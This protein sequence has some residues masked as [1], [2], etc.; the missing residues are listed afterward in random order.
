MQW[1]TS[2]SRGRHEPQDSTHALCRRA[3]LRRGPPDV[4][5]VRGCQVE[6]QFSPRWRLCADGAYYQQCQNG[7]GDR[8]DMGFV[9]C[10][11]PSQ[12]RICALL[13]PPS[14][15]DGWWAGHGRVCMAPW[16]G[17]CC[18]TARG[19]R[20]RRARGILSWSGG[21]HRV[22]S[23]AS[24]GLP[25]AAACLAAGCR[26]SRRHSFRGCVGGQQQGGRAPQRL[27]A[28]PL[29]ITDCCLRA[30]N[31][32]SRA[33]SMRVEGLLQTCGC[34]APTFHLTHE[35]LWIA[36]PHAL[37]AAAAAPWPAL[38]C[39]PMRWPAC[40]VASN[41]SAVTGTLAMRVE[42]ALMQQ[43]PRAAA[44]HGERDFLDLHCKSPSA[45]VAVAS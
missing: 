21:P 31:H 19:V 14:C 7:L 22:P 43:Q 8:G 35:T 1:R 5:Y 29:A 42:R 39:A 9:P 30:I 27:L 41:L 11:S 20:D 40:L 37:C 13:A 45:H 28:R 10:F 12:L 3:P 18:R 32:C 15:V 16:R 38:T 44:N 6:H 26:P 17:R 2:S 34:A 4:N 33:P 24:A 25:A 36:A 23:C